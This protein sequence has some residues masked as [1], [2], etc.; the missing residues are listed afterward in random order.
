MSIHIMLLLSG[1]NGRRLWRVSKDPNWYTRLAHNC[2][3]SKQDDQIGQQDCLIRPWPTTVGRCRRHRRRRHSCLRCSRR[4]WHTKAMPLK[5]S[6][7]LNTLNSHYNM[8]IRG[9]I[10]RV[11]VSIR[12]LN[13]FRSSHPHKIF[14]IG[15]PVARSP[16]RQSPHWQSISVT[17]NKSL[18]K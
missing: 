7:H 8:Y 16:G 5:R 14:K 6:R 3:M 2:L 13:T 18:Y 10:C 15:I 11:C 9:Y 4:L 17:P 1:N 12:I